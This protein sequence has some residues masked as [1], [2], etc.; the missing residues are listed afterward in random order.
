[1]EAMSDGQ[2]GAVLKRAPDGLLDQSICLSIHGCCGLIQNQHLDQNQPIKGQDT[3]T[4]KVQLSVCLTLHCL[5]RA[6]AT[7][8]SCLS[9]TEK[10]SPFSTTSDS[11]FIGS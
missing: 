11:N 4:G 5:S 1:M 8:S 2:R 3:G 7:H 9:P 6:L 10:F